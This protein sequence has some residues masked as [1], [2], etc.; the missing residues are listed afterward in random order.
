MAIEKESRIKGNPEVVWNKLLSTL[1]MNEY[2]IK[3]QIPHTQIVAEKG[4]RL[5]SSMIGG[6][7]GG[8]RTAEIAMNA[9]GQDNLI[10]FKFTFSALGAGT[11]WQG[12]KD[13]IDKMIG[14]F[15][16]EC[17]RD[18][19]VPTPPTPAHG[20][21]DST[22][23]KCHKPVNASFAICPFCGNHLKS[24]C[25]KCSKEVSGEFVVCP[26]CGQNLGQ[27]NTCKKCGKEL[28]P[29]FSMCPFCGTAR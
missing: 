8:F 14:A 22:C 28:K 29:E 23:P 24:T 18:A 17:S 26:F 5:V 6:T 27:Q 9:N 12:A 25:P 4:S 7:K 20:Q 10:K 1:S 11:A 21:S 13:E 3:S 16:H 15:E 2:T 19:P